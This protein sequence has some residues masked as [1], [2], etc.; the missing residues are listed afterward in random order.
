MIAFFRLDETVS[1]LQL[2]NGA[3]KTAGRGVPADT[4]YFGVAGRIIACFGCAS[5]LRVCRIRGTGRS[6]ERKRCVNLLKF[7]LRGFAAAGD[8]FQFFQR[9]LLRDGIAV[10]ITPEDRVLRFLHK[11]PEILRWGHVVS[12]FPFCPAFEPHVFVVFFH[13]R[14][15]GNDD[16]A[17]FLVDLE[18]LEIVFLTDK[19]VDVPDGADVDLGAG[20][21]CFH[22]VQVDQDAAFD[23][24]LHPAADHAAFIM[25]RNEF[26]PGFDE[27]RLPQADAGLVLLVFEFFQ[28]HV[29]LVADFDFFPVLE[30]GAGD[31]PFGLQTDID[32]YAIL[33]L[34]DDRAGHDRVDP[35]IAFGLSAQQIVQRQVVIQNDI[36]FLNDRGIFM[37]FCAHKLVV[38]SRFYVAFFPLHHCIFS[39]NS[40]AGAY[41]CASALL[42]HLI[43]SSLF[44]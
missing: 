10:R 12:I 43:A 38:F 16:V 7:L 1:A 11:I 36:G 42:N 5:A 2:D 28:V 30:L 44:F 17:A 35:E 8:A 6:D 40:R 31:E 13:E 4:R 9:H 22:A 23:F 21:E 41:P 20:E 14:A 15:A 34:L 33:A 18:N 37:F 29:D 27:V 3:L 32:Q 25:V 24:L 19:I 26:V 39:R